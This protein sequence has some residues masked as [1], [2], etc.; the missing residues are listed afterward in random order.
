VADWHPVLAAV[1]T[2]PGECSMPDPLGPPYALVRLVEV[3]GE[4]CYRVVT[5]APQSTARRLIGYYRNLRAA[6]TAANQWFVSTRNP[7][8]RPNPGWK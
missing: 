3:H 6:T 7:R 8:D 1:E 2:A 4:R 5:Y